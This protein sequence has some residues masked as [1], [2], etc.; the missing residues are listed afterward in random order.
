[1]A[2]SLPD[3]PYEVDALAPNM[4]AKTLALHHG[5]HHRAY[6]T[7]LNELIAG[8]PFES[9]SLINIIRTSHGSRD[10]QAIFNNAGQHWNHSMF[11]LS[12]TPGGSAVPANLQRRIVA[13]FGSLQ[14]FKSEFLAQG[15]AQ[16][17]S[18]WVWLVEIHGDLKIL[19]TPNAVSPLTNHCK[20]LLVCDVWEHAYYVD[21]ENRRAEYLD[22]FLEHLVD[23]PTVANRLAGD[24]E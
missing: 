20:A 11:W 13:N 10:T 12:M 16:F 5:K 24:A 9:M 23:W 18:G 14:G 22:S 6:V 4:S 17:G 3:L 2:F 1:V 15:V 21:Y 19:K 8:K 7:K